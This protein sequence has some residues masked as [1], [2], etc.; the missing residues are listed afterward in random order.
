MT[1]THLTPNELATR[2]H[3]EK[4]TLAAWRCK[5]SGPQFIKPTRKIVLY[6]I[7]AVE[8]WEISILKR[9]TVG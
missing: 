8:A 2:L 1:P 6:P 7:A 5:G 9:S 3:T 4:S